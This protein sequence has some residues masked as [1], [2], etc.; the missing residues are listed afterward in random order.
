MSLLF[1]FLLL[2]LRELSLTRFRIPSSI[3]ELWREDAK[4]ENTVSHARE[5]LKTAERHLSSMM[6]RVSYL[7]ALFLS[8]QGTNFL[9]T[10]FLFRAVQDTASGLRNLD[11]I[12]EALNLDGVYGP[13]YSLFEVDEKYSLA[14]EETAGNRQVC[15]CFCVI[16]DYSTLIFLS[17]SVFSMWW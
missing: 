8:Y 6:D 15:R 10:P 1:I 12:V 13:L 2:G 17:H 16:D 5:E 11:R 4:L 14:V 9:N 3:R 7:V